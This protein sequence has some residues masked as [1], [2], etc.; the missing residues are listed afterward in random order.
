MYW[1]ILPLVAAIYD[2]KTGEIPDWIT[3]PGVVLAFFYGLLK[4]PSILIPFIS[5]AVVGYF[6]YRYGFVG[7]GD[8][9][10]ILS[11]IPFISNLPGGVFLPFLVLLGGFVTTTTLYGIYYQLKKPLLLA[12]LLFIPIFLIPLY[13]TL[14]FALVGKERF[15]REVN[16]NELKEEDVLAEIPPGFNK[17]VIEKGDKERL[18]ALGYEKVKILVNLPKMGPGLFLTYLFLVFWREAVKFSLMIPVQAL[19]LLF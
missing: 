2:W 14:L 8:V 7:G 17:K 18:R 15:V 6:M 19:F 16:V 13:G 11:T 4:Q 12:P 5:F 1:L 9:L 3:I 10:L